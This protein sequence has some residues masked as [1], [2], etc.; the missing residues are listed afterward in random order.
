MTVSRFLF[1]KRDFRQL[2]ATAQSGTDKLLILQLDST[3]YGGN[4]LQKFSVWKKSVLSALI[5]YLS[6]QT[7]RRD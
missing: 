2:L 7:L 3:R 5:P 4:G 1:L 6:G